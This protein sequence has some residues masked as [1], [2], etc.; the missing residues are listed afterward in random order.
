MSFYKSI[1]HYRGFDF[2]GFNESVT[3]EKITSILS[4]EK[5][6]ETDYLALLSDAA[7]P[8]LEQMAQKAD[9]LT[10]RHFGNVVF[11]FTPLYISNYCEN[12]CAYCSFGRQQRIKRRHLSLNE[13]RDEAQRI[14]ATGIRHILMLTG[15]AR[16]KASPAYCEAAVRILRDYFAS[17]AIEI[18][19]LT[20]DEYGGI[21]QS[22]ADGL[23]IYQE[24]YDEERYSALHEGGPKQ[25]YMFRL[26][27][28]ERAC[29]QGVRSVG[30]GALLGLSEPVV[31]SFLCGL[32]AAYLQRTFPD[33]E[34][35]VSF[36]R[37][38]PL[39][40]DFT[41]EYTVNDRL[42]V[43]MMTALR[44]FLPSA[45]ITLSTR[46]SAFFRNAAV[47]LGVT[48][49]SAGVSTA[50]GGHASPEAT[51]QFEIADTRT[52][53][54]VQE[55]LLCLGFQPVLHD[56]NSKYCKETTVTG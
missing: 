34:V 21:I 52:L 47:R 48:K 18:Y 10:R 49:M 12:K 29:R 53:T 37:L 26:E 36:P 42:L 28:P 40:G 45:G 22:G 23:T 33:V 3:P 5:L 15:E 39:V 9:A 16:R 54:Q 1:E 4:R 35:S 43:Q 2:S 6:A 25:D 51:P 32:H 24:T 55:D 8:F 41:Q 31:D 38:R 44:L 46:E 27:A 17:V 13:I 14:S 30:V 50:V 56:W 19:P 20:E 11:I 7:T